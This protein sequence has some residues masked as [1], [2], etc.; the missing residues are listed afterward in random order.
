[1]AKHYRKSSR[2]RRSKSRKHRTRRH[3]KQQGG[4]S[5]AAMPLNREMFAQR[6]GMAP[7]QAGGTDYLVDASTRVQ[8]EVGPLDQAF[9]E[10]PA[11]LKAAGVVPNQL[12]GARRGHKSKKARHSRKRHSRKRHSRKRHSRKRHS[13]K[14]RGGMAPFDA[15]YEMYKGGVPL[16]PVPQRGGSA[17]SAVPAPFDEVSRPSLLPVGSLYGQ[18]PQFVTEAGVNSLYR[19]EGGAQ[20]A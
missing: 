12:G 10:L 5:C 6:G 15:P 19:Y 7:Y 2:S 20:T 14:Q 11:V 9:G 1:M 17:Q 4:G 13:R 8:A 16:I 3:R 18:N